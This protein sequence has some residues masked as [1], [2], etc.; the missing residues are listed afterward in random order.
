MKNTTNAWIKKEWII[1]LQLQCPQ[2]NYLKNQNLKSIN[3]M[4][5]KIIPTINELISDKDAFKHDQLK[6]L[7]NQDPPK[8]WIKTN[9]YANNSQYVPVDKVEYMLDKIFQVWRLEILDARQMFNA[10]AVTIRLH[11]KHPITGEMEYHDGGGCKVLQTASGSGVLKPDFSNITQNAVEIALPIAISN[12]LK[13]A[14]HH[15]GRIFG[16]DLNRTDVAEYKQTYEPYNEDN[17]V[18]K[19]IDQATTKEELKSIEH[20]VSD[21]TREAYKSK[22]EAL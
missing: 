21:T 3:T 8:M 19:F 5:K 13:D 7:L 6:M 17:Q 4:S 15:L 9:K 22:I 10:V 2:K 12:A 1:F 20:M 18:I 11:Y 14:A 16:R